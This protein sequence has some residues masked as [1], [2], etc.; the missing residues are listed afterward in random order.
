MKTAVIDYG[1]G[2]LASVVQGLIAVGLEPVITRNEEEILKA[3]AV[4]LPGVGAFPKGMENL[5]NYGLL[6]V[7]SE[8]VQRGTYFLGI[9]LGM[10]LLFEESEEHGQ[11]E[12]LGFLPG[13]IKRFPPGLK[14]PHMGWNTLKIEKEHPIL[15]DTPAE[16]YTYFVHSYYACDLK[17]EHLL[18]SSNY[19]VDF[20]AVVCFENIIGMQFHPE[21]SSRVGLGILK[22]FGELVLRC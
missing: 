10:Q 1:I 7:I 12:G 22:N 15:K 4:I 9:C 13:K 20:P 18:A 17:P 5:K 14:I 3:K 16:S 8:V 2:N 11:C 19:G 21:K 6:P